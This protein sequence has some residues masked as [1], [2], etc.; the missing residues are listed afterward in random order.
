MANAV[1]W[2]EIPATNFDRA[3]KFYST[4]LDKQLAINEIMGIQMAMLPAENNGV[5]G[6]ICTGEGHVPSQDG[7]TIYLN[8]GED[9]SDPLSRVESAGGKVLLPK[10]KITD[11]IGYFAVF[12]DCEGNKVAF[13]SPS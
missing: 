10:T 9:L 7:S 1:N 13:H 3:S 6:A 11:E 4:V 8:G 5:G 2:F 12:L